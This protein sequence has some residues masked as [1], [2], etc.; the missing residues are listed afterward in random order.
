M[1]VPPRVIR[2]PATDSPPVLTVAAVHVNPTT[3]AVLQPEIN[4]RLPG[5]RA[6]PLNADYP[7]PLGEQQIR[8]V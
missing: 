7:I 8:E 4:A 5:G 2:Y 3:A 1:I 6:R